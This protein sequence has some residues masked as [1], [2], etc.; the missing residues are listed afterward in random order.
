M[1]PLYDILFATALLSA[2]ASSP[3]SMHVASVDSWIAEDKAR[4]AAAAFAAT[5]F[6]Q[7]GLRS[8]GVETDAAVPIAAAVAGISGIVKEVH[9]SKNGGTFSFRDL[10]WDAVGIIAGVMVTSQAR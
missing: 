8:T 2:P 4:H 1:N 9:D 5:A 10:A 7:A 6:V 3:A